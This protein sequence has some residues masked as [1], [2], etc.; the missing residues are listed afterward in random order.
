VNVRAPPR[1]LPALAAAAL[2]AA[3]ALSAVRC[4]RNV[5]LG[6][7]PE[8]DAAAQDGGGDAAAPD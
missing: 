8:S 2:A 4:D 1:K 5:P 6:V 3:L 7:A